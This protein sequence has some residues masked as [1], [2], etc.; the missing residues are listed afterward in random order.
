MNREELLE[1]FA[2][3][4]SEDQAA[5]RKELGGDRKDFCKTMMQEMQNKCCCGRP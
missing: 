5:I 1:A 4:S 3:L 2:E